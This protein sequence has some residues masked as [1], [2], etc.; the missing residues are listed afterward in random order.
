M[1]QFV[2]VA[3]LAFLFLY[4]APLPLFIL[5]LKKDS[6]WGGLVGAIGAILIHLFNILRISMLTLS[7]AYYEVYWEIIHRIDAYV[8]FYPLIIS[9]WYSA[10][11]FHEKKF[12]L[13]NN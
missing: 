6:P 9:L 3:I 12:S 2:V 5:G 7:M 11:T 13:S 1:L 4:L 10:S 8:I